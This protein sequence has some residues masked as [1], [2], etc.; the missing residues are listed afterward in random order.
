MAQFF[1]IHPT[2]PQERL[3]NQAADIVR[4]GGVIVYPTD[5]CYALGCQLGNKQAMEQILRIRDIDQKH[6]LTLMC[7]DLSQLGL[8]PELIIVSIDCLKRPRPAAI[9]LFYRPLRKYLRAR[10]IRSA[11]RLACVYQITVLLYLYCKILVNQCYRA[12]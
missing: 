3:I 9:H 4:K 5:S 7:H 10:C 12:R 6:H 1:A 2:D 11:K 8:Y